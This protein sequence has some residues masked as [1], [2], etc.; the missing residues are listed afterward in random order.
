MHIIK[1]HLHTK[2]ASTRR[3]GKKHSGARCLASVTETLKSGGCLKIH[4]LPLT[5]W[6]SA[7]STDHSLLVSFCLC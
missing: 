6:D 3:D 1:S 4:H 5:R 2:E 7:A